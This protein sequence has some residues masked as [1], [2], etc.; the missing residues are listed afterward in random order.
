MSRKFTEAVKP[1]MQ[2]QPQKIEI[3]FGDITLPNVENPRD[4]AETMVMELENAFKQ[5]QF[6]N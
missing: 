2:K 4:F 6:Q 5:K 3:N 1:T